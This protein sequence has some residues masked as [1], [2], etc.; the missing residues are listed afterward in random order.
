VPRFFYLNH[1]HIANEMRGFKDF[2][3]LVMVTDFDPATGTDS[4]FTG[5]D[6]FVFYEDGGRPMDIQLQA[7]WRPTLAV[8]HQIARQL[9]DVLDYFRMKKVVH[10][11]LSLGTVVC[12]RENNIKIISLGDAKFVGQLDYEQ[13]VQEF[14][15]QW[16]GVGASS[17]SGS[18]KPNRPE[19]ELQN[20]TSKKYNCA[21]PLS[22]Y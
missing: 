6:R 4:P 5:N 15:T 12:D 16:Q 18:R 20:V 14:T 17:C 21:D 13:T 2:H 7:G 22:R 3:P 1:P 10:R 19:A 9:V 8:V 11:K